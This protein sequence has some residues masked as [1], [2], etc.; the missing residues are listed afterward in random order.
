[1]SVRSFTRALIFTHAVSPLTALLLLCYARGKQMTGWFGWLRWL[2]NRCALAFVR[3]FVHVA[4]RSGK[5]F[6]HITHIRHRDPAIVVLAARPF[7]TFVLVSHFAARRA[8]TLWMLR[9][10]Q[11]HHCALLWIVSS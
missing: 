3:S 9:E 5:C 7:I 1:M 2:G 6:G 4:K 10:E 8:H 11:Q